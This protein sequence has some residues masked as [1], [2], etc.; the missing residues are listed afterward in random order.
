MSERL[1][2]TAARNIF[3]RGE[4]P[5]DGVLVVHSAIRNL[6]QQGFRA[7]AFIDAMLELLPRG[8]LTMPA[9]SWRVCTPENPYFD[10]L[11][12]PSIVGALSEVFRTRYA[13]VRSIHPTHSFCA[14]GPRAEEL[15]ADHF[16]GNTPC[17][18]DSPIGR[19]PGM[20][21]RILLLGVGFESCTLI[22]YPEEV[23]A[24]DFYLRPADGVV[25]R[26]TDKFSAVHAVEARRHWRLNRDF[27][28]FGRRLDAAGKLVAGDLH[29]T[30]WSVCR[31]TDLC[32]SVFAAL[33]DRIEGTL[34][35]LV[36]G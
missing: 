30:S 14:I 18:P 27:P 26:C 33:A 3:E 25:Y 2:R 6:S 24:P 21:A 36:A 7:E 31:A 15:V 13:R 29:G 19:M 28:K 4:I 16:K 8:T 32:E 35:D 20:D 10:E 11:E 1:E 12:T 22:H 17:P 5:A 9:M 23:V 34:G